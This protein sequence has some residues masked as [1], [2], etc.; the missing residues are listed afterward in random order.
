MSKVTLNFTAFT[1][2]SMGIKVLAAMQELKDTG[3]VVRIQNRRK[4]DFLLCTVHRDELGYG[5][6]F[7][8]TE[9]Q[10]V[11][12]LIQRAAHMWSYAVQQAV[13]ALFAWAN[14]LTAHPALLKAKQAYVVE[15]MKARGA[16]HV[17]TTYGGAKLYGGFQRDWLCRKRM[18]VICDTK[19]RVC[20]TPRK[21]C[22]AAAA[23]IASV[24]A[25]V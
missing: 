25:L 12:K 10:D 1:S 23:M 6:R 4:T 16:T 20:A 14:D 9:N 2:A 19:G 17:F 13:W 21:L 8:T 5:F 24:E 11:T 18:Y 15:E 22:K 7:I 3:H